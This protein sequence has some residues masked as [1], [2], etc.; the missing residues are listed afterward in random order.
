[1]KYLLITL[2]LVSI[3][4]CADYVSFQDANEAIKVGFWYGLW[5]GMIIPISFIVSLLDSDV[6][7]Y[8]IYNNGCWYDFGFA[9]GCGSLISSGR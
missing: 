5:H 7:I 1:M 6:A 3:T 4:G 2:F 8:A 9:L